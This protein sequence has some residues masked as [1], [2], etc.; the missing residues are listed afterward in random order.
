MTHKSIQKTW[1]WL[2]VVGLTVFFGLGWYPLARLLPPHPPSAS[3]E[4]IAEIYR[5]HTNGIRAGTLMCMIGLMFFYPF[6]GVIFAQMRR[7]ERARGEPAFH[8]IIQVVCGAAAYTAGIMLPLMLWG[9]GAFRPD[10]DPN[11]TQMINDIAWLLA[12]MVFSPYIPQFL[13]FALEILRDKEPKPLFPRWVGWLNVW[14]AVSGLP[15]LLIFFFKTGPFAW[16]GIISFW[17]PFGIF[18]I[19]LA[20][21]IFY[22]FK[23]VDRDDYPA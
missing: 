1:L 15:V 12:T 16:N 9:I 6:A 13:A 20:I 4:Q 3:A 18:F 19:G 2:M 8:S 7:I 14:I 21:T 10:R 22:L 5:L 17:L 23:A 11:L